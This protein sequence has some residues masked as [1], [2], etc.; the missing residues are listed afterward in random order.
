MGIV[1]FAIP[2]QGL[3]L[4]ILKIELVKPKRE[5]QWRL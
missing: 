4:R 1:S 3:P 5:L 2:F